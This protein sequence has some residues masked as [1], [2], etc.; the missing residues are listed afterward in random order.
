MF[1]KDDVEMEN[2]DGVKKE[3]EEEG[4]KEM[5]KRQKDDYSLTPHLSK[6][7]TLIFP[8]PGHHSPS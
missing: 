3:E 1:C 6:V 4:I 7:K 5:I 2:E 8:A